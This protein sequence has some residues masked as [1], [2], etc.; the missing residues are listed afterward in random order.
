MM[1][2]SSRMKRHTRQGLEG[3][4]HRGFF[5]LG[6]GVYHHPTTWMYSPTQQ[7]SAPCSFR[8][9]GGFVSQ[10]WLV[11]SLAISD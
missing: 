6:F 3:S 10:E 2:I 1:Q 8:D 9:F 11:R 5:P 4:Q 7:P